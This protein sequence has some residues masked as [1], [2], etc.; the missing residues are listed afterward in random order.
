GTSCVGFVLECLETGFFSIEGAD[1]E[2]AIALWEKIDNFVRNDWKSDGNALVYALSLLGW[3]IYYW[4][5][6][7]SREP[8]KNES[9]FNEAMQKSEYHG[10]ITIGDNTSLVNFGRNPGDRFEKFPF[11]VGSAHEGYHVFSGYGGKVTEAHSGL[12][13]PFVK[14]QERTVETGSFNPFVEKGSPRSQL[15]SGLLAVPPGQ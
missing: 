14:D 4:N 10:G 5:P 2:N 9:D 11:Y 15:F 6:N 8:L 1:R 13:E 12:I 3:K 7:T